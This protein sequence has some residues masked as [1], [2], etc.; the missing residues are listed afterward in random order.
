[1]QAVMSSS[2][3]ASEPS[4]ELMSAVVAAVPAVTHPRLRRGIA[5]LARVS[6]GQLEIVERLRGH[7]GSIEERSDLRNADAA[8][9]RC[10]GGFC[11]CG[12][13]RS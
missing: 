5:G 7:L 3:I 12:R 6:A 11:R 13:S 9:R 4:A 1:M 8:M 2:P 10:S